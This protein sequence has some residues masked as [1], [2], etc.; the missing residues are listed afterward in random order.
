MR[1]GTLRGQ[2]QQLGRYDLLDQLGRGGSGSVFKARQRDTG[3]LVAVKILAPEVAADPVL[4]RRFEQEFAT[5]RT[6]DHPHIVRALDFGRED[7]THFL[8]LELVDGPSLWDHA[9]TT[10]RLSAADAIRLITQIGGA[11]DFAHGRGILHRDVKPDN[12]LIKAAQGL[13]KLT[14]AGPCQGR[15][16][17]VAHGDGHGAGHSS[18][19]G[20]RAIR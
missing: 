12:I 13:A 10:G 3:A 18:F 9:R 6:L 4:L 20:P 15:N 19:H 2:Q 14:D 16:G 1:W 11:L 17:A 5:T 8:V 7:Q